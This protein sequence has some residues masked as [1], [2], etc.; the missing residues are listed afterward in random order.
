[1]YIEAVCQGLNK[2]PEVAPDI[3]SK[4]YQDLEKYGL[5]KLN[6]KLKK[7]DFNSWKKIDLK[8]PRKVIRCLEVYFSTKKP[9]SSFLNKKLEEKEFEILYFFLNQERKLLYEKINNRVEKMISNGL[10]N[11]VK[12]V[13]LQK[14]RKPLQTIG[15][16]EFFDFFEKKQ[17]LEKTISLIKQNTRRYAK[18]QITWF[19][20][21]KYIEI[22]VSETK[23]IEKI[24]KKKGKIKSSLLNKN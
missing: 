3:R 15:Y 18:R 9:I 2:I 6:A 19:K 1:M 14:D 12:K 8:N 16:K 11:E 4:L 21:K 22:D 23:E 20:G 13:I 10:Q 17:S 5:E 7:Y 24:I